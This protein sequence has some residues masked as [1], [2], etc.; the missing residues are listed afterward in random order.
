M[1][2]PAVLCD[3]CGR[4][5]AAVYQ[6][7]TGRRLCAQCF[8]EDVRARV[9]AEVKRWRM[10]EPGD[11]LML[12]LSGGKDSFT[13]LDVIPDNLHPAS[14]VYAV[15]IVEGIP[16]YNRHVDIE[17]MKRYARERGVDLIVTSIREYTGLYLSEIVSGA[18]SRKLRISPC[19]Y[20]GIL[21]RRIINYYARIYGATKTVT[22][23]N[24]DDEAQT[25]VVNILRGDVVGLLR[26]HPLAPP[27]S[28]RLVPR[29]KPLRKIYEWETT[30]Y[31]FLKGF[32]FQETECMYIRYAPTLR[33]RVREALY[34]IESRAPGSLLRLLETLDSILAEPASKLSVERLPPCSSCGEPTSPNRSLCKLCEILK[35]AGVE[36]PIYSIPWRKL[37]RF[38]KAL[39]MRGSGVHGVE[40]EATTP[41][42]PE[43]A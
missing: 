26:Q 18:W 17:K 38:I 10:I 14:R 27:A 21:R 39:Y 43:A 30:T 13:L 36:R 15:S 19:T 41:R 12:A 32:K 31:A 1:A 7:H 25:A 11:T 37:P 28:E 8:I 9:A 24:L 40:E 16:N 3:A 22:A 23:H 42:G 4:R 33:A 2:S 35:A 34:L 20:C 5:P 29:I 6:P